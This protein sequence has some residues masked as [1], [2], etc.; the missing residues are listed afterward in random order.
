[1]PV[2]VT[3]FTTVSPIWDVTNAVLGSAWRALSQFGEEVRN[4]DSYVSLNE[5]ADL[6][7]DL[8]TAYVPDYGPDPR[9]SAREANSASP[10]GLPMQV[11]TRIIVQLWE[12]CYPTVDD[13]GRTPDP[14]TLS[15]VNERLYQHGF[16][17]FNGVANDYR[18]GDLFVA[19]CQCPRLVFGK[20]RPLGPRADCAGWT[21]EVLA[22]P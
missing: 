7:C 8:L 22:S 20:L 14:T 6:C 21:F 2:A 10:T 1:M 9:S 18:T 11:E 19:P 4:I 3:D 13:H 5:P 15:A 17:I 12:G 16:A